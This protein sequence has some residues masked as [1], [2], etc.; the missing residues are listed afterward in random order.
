MTIETEVA[1][2]TTQTTALLTAV[3][4]SKATLDQKV[5][6][7]T[8]QA[9]QAATNGAEQVALAA[10]QAALATTNGAAQV[11]LAAAQAAIATT[12]AGESSASAA[13]ATTKA[14][15]AEAARAAAVAAQNNAVAVVTGGT[16]SLKSAPGKLPLADANGRLDLSW[17]STLY[18]ALRFNDIGTPGAMGFGVGICPSLPEGFS[19]LAG[20]TDPASPNYGNYQYADGSIMCWIPAFYFRIGH[21]SNPTF[22]AHG[23]NSISVKPLSAYP[24]EASA[25]ADGFYLHRAFINAGA[26]QPGFFRDKYDCSN[27]GGIASSKPLAMPLVSGPSADQ[28]GFSAL[29]GAPA[30]AYHGAIPAAKTRGAKF[31]PESVFIADALCRLTEAHAQAAT[32]ST[33]CAWYDAA[34]VKNFPKGNNNNA[35]KDTDDL[36]VTFTAAGA[37]GAPNM[38]LTG[39]G[40]NFAKTTHNGQACGIADV[41]GN[42]YKIN[43]G[44]TCIATSKTITGATQA[45][46]VVLTVAGHGRT[47][48]DV[49]MITSVGGMTQ[50]TD[51]LYT[52]TVVDANRISLDGVDGTG[53]SAYTTGGSL[54][55]GTFY[56]LKSS[57]DIAAVTSGASSATDHWGATGVAAQFDAVPM[58]FATTY[59][60][61]AFAQRYGNAANAAFSM[62]PEADRARSMLGMPAAGG[63]STAGANLMGLDYY[64]QYIRDQLCVLSRGNWDNGSNAGSRF[65]SL[66]S[67][68]TNASVNVGF[69]AASYL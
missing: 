1:N 9:E 61:N 15:A 17:F 69:A 26:V 63:M 41:N 32:S 40:S 4:V 25:N 64:Y 28:V 23:A 21:A 47:T 33:Y 54:T 2:L 67:T 49:V 38:A 22:A 68:R 66:H 60:S 10:Q 14:A 16:G 55:T 51:R 12:K 65:R 58:N 20:T 3:N 53:F 34:G 44:M 46:P 7:A 52:V 19:A 42:I 8:E 57:A 56:A 18:P 36:S 27:N 62:A 50:I 6:A 45:S 37:S 24:G 31:F 13:T 43:P 30:N 5:A 11:A 35:L 59:P 39:S 48:G 29:D